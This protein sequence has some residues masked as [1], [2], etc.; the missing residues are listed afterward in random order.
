MRQCLGRIN[1]CTARPDCC[2]QLGLMMK[3]GRHGGVGQRS[4]TA[5]QRIG[6]LGEKE[7]RIPIRVMAHFTGMFG[8][9]APHAE[10]AADRKAVAAARNGKGGLHRRGDDEACHGPIV[11]HCTARAC[12]RRQARSA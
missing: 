12:R 1:I 4:T 5:D 8:I 11:K 7:G 9:V 3:V 2:D 6:R 10:D